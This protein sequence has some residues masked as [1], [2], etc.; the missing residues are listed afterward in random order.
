MG[1]VISELLFNTHAP[2]RWTMLPEL[3]ILS[4]DNCSLRL[5]LSPRQKA[6]NL[7]DHCTKQ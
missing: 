6:V 3:L 4:A 5:E 1:F 7:S 2:E